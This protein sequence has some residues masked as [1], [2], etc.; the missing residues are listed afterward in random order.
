MHHQRLVEPLVSHRRP[1]RGP[2]VHHGALRQR[3]KQFVRGLG[4]EHRRPVGPGEGLLVDR[5]AVAAGVERMEAGVGEPRLVEVEPGRAGRER[6]GDR[7]RVVTQ[8]VVRG[9]GEHRVLG[10][11]GHRARREGAGGDPLR[12]RPGRDAGGRQ[13]SGEAVAVAGG[14]EVD[15]T[16]ARDD[17]TVQDRLVAVAVHQGDLVAGRAEVADQAVAGGVAVQ[18][19]IAALGAEDP[20]GVALR[21]ADRPGVLEQRTEFLHRDRQ[22][23]AQQSFPEVVVEG[24]AHR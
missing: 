7:H 6:P 12:D 15:R 3:R 9:V 18:D 4:R 13:R 2:D 23:A 8:A 24:P 5:H 11:R 14:D 17:E 20:R 21:L 22:V 16:G 1:R 19:E 10:A